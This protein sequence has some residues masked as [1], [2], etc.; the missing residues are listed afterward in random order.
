MIPN[1]RNPL[2]DP[3]AY[4][5]ARDAQETIRRVDWA[6]PGLRV[7]RFRLLSDPGFPLWDVSYCHG[8]LDGEHVDVDLPFDQLPK[9]RVVSAVIAYARKDG[10]HAKRLGILDA[11][12]QLCF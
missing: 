5:A 4:H 10:V 3:Q 11:L 2:A 9:G 1:E 12:S 6:T 7:T 8:M